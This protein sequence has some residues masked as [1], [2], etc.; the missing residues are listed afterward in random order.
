[1]N[2]S[3]VRE[4]IPLFLLRALGVGL[5][6]L[7]TIHV[8]RVLG[9]EKLGI[10]TFVFGFVLQAGML[11]DLNQNYEI[12]RRGKNDADKTSLDRLIAEV[13]SYRLTIAICLTLIGLIGVVCMRPS[14]Q[15]TLAIACGFALI[16][17]QGNH[18]GW[19]LQIH[20]KM[21]Q[22]FSALS[23]Q[24]IV[25]GLLAL[26]FIRA[27]WPAGSDLA[28]GLVGSMLAFALAWRWALH[29]KHRLALSPRHAWNG[30]M[31]LKSGKWLALMGIA[32]YLL[33]SL[34]VLLIGALCPIEELGQY[35]TAT[36]LINLINPFLPLL[37]NK[38][39]PELIELE[40]TASTSVFPLQCKLALQT[41]LVGAPI[42]LL[43][44]LLAPH[45]YPLIFGQAYAA[46]ALPFVI[47]VGSKI[48][49]VAV[50][51]FMWGVFARHL[52]RK[53]VLLTFISAAIGI[54]ANV[55]LIPRWGAVGACSV[56][57]LAQL[58]LLAG[59]ALVMRSST[60][61]NLVVSP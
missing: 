38:L 27:D 35:R 5:S 30:M 45:I 4:H 39:Y 49:S 34:E 6:A 37:F 42:V 9:P 21:A 40:K 26:A 60:T 33:S 1:M 24:G 7:G 44:F 56:N 41:L 13:F 36:Q 43:A 51:I 25:T 10:S 22:Y 57:L 55:L 47:L 28:V 11:I 15:W 3:K 17:F 29:G 50:N 59:Y 58:I 23:I 2:F 61:R 52:D 18:A 16:F 14:S 19:L 46:A 31:I 12:V 48:L 20:G 53:A 54:S 32:T 8:A